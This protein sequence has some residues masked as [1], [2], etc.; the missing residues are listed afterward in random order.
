MSDGEIPLQ[1]ASMI[2]EHNDYVLQELLGLSDAEV[3]DLR[4][5]EVIM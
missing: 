5:S 4:T 3:A 2:G 1:C